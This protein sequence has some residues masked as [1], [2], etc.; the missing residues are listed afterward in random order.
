MS[1]ISSF[2]NRLENRGFQCELK[3]IKISIDG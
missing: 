2:E 3:I 1:R